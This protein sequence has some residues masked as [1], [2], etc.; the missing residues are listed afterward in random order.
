MQ[1]QRSGAIAAHLGR[2]I[3][4]ITALSDPRRFATHRLSSCPG[5]LPILTDGPGLGSNHQIAAKERSHGSR[6]QQDPEEDRQDRERH[7]GDCVARR[8]RHRPAP[9]LSPGACA[10]GAS[11]SEYAGTVEPAD[12]CGRCERRS[13]DLRRHDS[14]PVT[15]G[16]RAGCRPADPDGPRHSRRVT[17]IT[18]SRIA[19]GQ[20]DKQP[21]DAADHQP[22]TVEPFDCSRLHSFE[23]HT[24]DA[25]TDHQ[26]HTDSDDANA[27]AHDPHPGADAN[28]D[29]HAHTDSNAD[30]H[31]AAAN[32]DDDTNTDHEAS[33]DVNETFL[34]RRITR[35]WRAIGTTNS[36]TVTEPH[37][38]VAATQIAQH[39]LDQ[40]DQAVSRFN[41]ASELTR[42]N[43]AATRGPVNIHVSTIFGDVLKSALSAAE[44]TGGIVTPTIGR[45]LQECGYDVDIAIVQTRASETPV[46]ASLRPSP[47]WKMIQYRPSDGHLLIPQ[48]YQLD[49]GA[50]AKAAAAD[51]IAAKLAN[52]LPGGFLVN[53]GGDIAVDGVEPADGWPVAVDD[54]TGATLQVV[55]GHRN[56]F[57]TSSTQ[58]RSWIQG[59]SRMHH[60]I[61]PRTGRASDIA[62]SQVTCAAMS[63]IVANAASTASIVLGEH[64]PAWLTEMGIPARLE[65]QSG[66]A[67]FTPGWPTMEAIAA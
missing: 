32:D 26:S 40:L 1:G 42:V 63:T 49:F 8:K 20:S 12:D 16:S 34:M 56:A 50:T 58:K 52:S 55:A 2:A 30:D 54:H 38:V 18:D 21:D 13:G 25:H 61:D 62:W 35:S 60:I 51:A 53:L 3:D 9:P 28:S 24:V 17:G 47:D 41:P 57:A 4:G 7:D 27:N 15:F 14:G 45:A 67:V 33:G 19:R 48:G 39:Y 31:N 65:R 37:T 22:L 43:V 36:V 5:R 29:T 23:P 10:G 44:L 11:S 46:A 64:A 59:T 66:P 6:T